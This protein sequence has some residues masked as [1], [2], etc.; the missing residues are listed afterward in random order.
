[1][2]EL[3]TEIE[4]DGTPD[5]IWSVLAD[6]PAHS[7]WNPFIREIDGELRVGGKLDVRL[8]PVDERGITMRPTVLAADPG[9]ELRWIGQPRGSWHLR[10]RAPLPDRR[11]AAGY[12]AP[13]SCGPVID[14]PRDRLA[15]PRRDRGRAPR[16]SN[17]KDPIAGTRQM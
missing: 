7:E 14:A 4:F 6:L 1:M 10:R 15:G 17:A 5:E 3:R 9:R 11:G 16:S 13:I 8:Q 12:R 2:K